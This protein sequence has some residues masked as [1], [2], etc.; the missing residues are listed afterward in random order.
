MPSSP[1][2]G[3]GVLATS[4]IW[5]G[6]LTVLALCDVVELVVA[7]APLRLILSVSTSAHLVIA[8]I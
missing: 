7:N 5:Q 4:I 3:G 1:M 6:S 8:L 2:R